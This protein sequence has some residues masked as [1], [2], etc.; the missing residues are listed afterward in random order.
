M[1]IIKI[2]AG[3]YCLILPIAWG[4]SFYYF[5]AKDKCKNLSTI[6][7]VALLMH[8]ITFCFWEALS[9]FGLE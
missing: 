4:I 5:G 9:L 1:E 6:L 2:I 7:T 8:G 3:I